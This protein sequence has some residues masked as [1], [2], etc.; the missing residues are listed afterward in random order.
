MLVRQRGKKTSPF[1]D[2]APCRERERERKFCPTYRLAESSPREGPR[3]GRDASASWS[4]KW[5][6]GLP[7]VKLARG[8]SGRGNVADPLRIPAYQT[9]P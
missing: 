5:P 1:P 8:F 4:A 9:S 6:G 7:R 2:P 3:N